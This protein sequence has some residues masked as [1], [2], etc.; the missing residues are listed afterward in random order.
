M[1]NIIISICG[2]IGVIGLITGGF[3]IISSIFGEIHDENIK[4][5]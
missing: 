5:D 2:V 1:T 4:E 3:L